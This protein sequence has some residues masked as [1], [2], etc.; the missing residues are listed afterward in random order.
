MNYFEDLKTQEAMKKEGWLPSWCGGI[1][2]GNEHLVVEIKPSFAVRVT[3]R[4][5]KYPIATFGPFDS[6]E[7]AV[8]VA[9]RKWSVYSDVIRDDINSTTKKAEE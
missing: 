7:L 1:T 2:K 9:N 8:Q 3:T 5:F 6:F 4:S